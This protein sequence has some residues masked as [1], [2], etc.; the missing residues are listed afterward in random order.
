MVTN[1]PIDVAR[2]VAF[3]SDDSGWVYAVNLTSGT[4]VWS[5]QLVTK[6]QPPPR[7][8]TALGNRALFMDLAV[9]GNPSD[10]DANPGWFFTVDPLTGERQQRNWSTQAAWGNAACWCV[11]QTSVK[12]VV[13]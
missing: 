11:K 4:E 1:V 12:S 8:R 10:A 13:H 5:R 2:G 6:K 3:V 7:I 9:D